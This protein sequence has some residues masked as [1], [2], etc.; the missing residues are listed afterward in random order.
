LNSGYDDCENDSLSARGPAHSKFG[1]QLQRLQRIIHD[2][3]LD[4]GR[5]VDLYE[6]IHQHLEL[7]CFESR[8]A[9]LVARS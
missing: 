7:S 1:D 5:F 9:N 3:P 6:D 8:T 4:I 2:H